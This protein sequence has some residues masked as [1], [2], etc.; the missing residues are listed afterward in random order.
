M[1]TNTQTENQMGFTFDMPE[2]NVSGFV[3]KKALFKAPLTAEE[4]IALNSWDY[5]HQVALETKI[6]ARSMSVL[7]TMKP[8]SAEWKWEA[9]WV[10]SPELNFNEGDV[11]SMS[12]EK[13]SEYRLVELFSDIFE[14][15]D[16]S[17]YYECPDLDARRQMVLEAMPLEAQEAI[18]DGSYQDNNP[19]PCGDV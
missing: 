4:K 18:M 12:F 2:E 13:L 11:Q 19:Y 9:A 10:F 16:L 17:D 5:N 14:S 1:T 6:L 3:S 7:T 15:V 8:N